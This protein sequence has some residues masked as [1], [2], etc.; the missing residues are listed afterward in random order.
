M[1]AL[2]SSFP[3]EARLRELR[4]HPVGGPCIAARDLLDWRLQEPSLDRRWLR[5]NPRKLTAS[6][7][8]GAS[9][10]RLLHLPSCGGA[11]M[12]RRRSERNRLHGGLPGGLLYRRIFSI[13]FRAA[14]PQRSAEFRRRPGHGGGRRWVGM[15]AQ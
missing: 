15:L 3:G 2:S 11:L 9:V 1:A 4:E 5:M 8:F 12:P 10:F 6:P 13:A 14:S 7:V